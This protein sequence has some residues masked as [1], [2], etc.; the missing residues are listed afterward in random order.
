MKIISYSIFGKEQIYRKCLLHNIEIAKKL[1]P[2]WKIFIHLNLQN[3]K[4]QFLKDIKQKNTEIIDL[5]EDH[6][7]MVFFGE[8][9]QWKKIMML[10]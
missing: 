6:L 7:K 1:F 2:E 9:F 5:K 3:E 8:C 4:K 10:L